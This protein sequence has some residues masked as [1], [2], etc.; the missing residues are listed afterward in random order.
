[1]KS[2]TALFSNRSVLTNLLKHGARDNIPN[3][4]SRCVPILST[5]SKDIK[6]MMNSW[7][8]EL[9][10]TVT[11]LTEKKLRNQDTSSDWLAELCSMLGC[12]FTCLRSLCLLFW[13][14]VWSSSALLLSPGPCWTCHS[15]VTA[16]ITPLTSPKR[17]NLASVK[18][19]TWTFQ[20]PKATFSTQPSTCGTICWTTISTCR[21]RMRS[22]ISRCC[23]FWCMPLFSFA[24]LLSLTSTFSDIRNQRKW[25]VLWCCL[26]MRWEECTSSYTTTVWWLFIWCFVYISSPNEGYG[27]LRQLSV[28]RLESRREFW[29]LFLGF[30]GVCSGSMEQCHCWRLYPLSCCSRFFLH[31][32][33]VDLIG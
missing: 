20:L 29:R 10:Y 5:S 30:W 19:T 28:S 9:K 31:F 11:T 4:T 26:M 18:P 12:F 13:W 7:A 24:S 21:H 8:K 2:Y 14:R 22:T 15:I 6:V 3:T 25:F 23:T 27:L 32:R 33:F 17:L 16:P 1:M